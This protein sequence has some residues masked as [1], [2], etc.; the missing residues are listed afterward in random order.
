MEMLL[1][2]EIGTAKAIPH[3][4]HFLREN[5]RA[6]LLPNFLGIVEH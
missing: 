3:G 1:K 5:E 4:V 2:N 6:S